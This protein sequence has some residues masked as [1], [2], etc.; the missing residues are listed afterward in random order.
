MSTRL[1]ILLGATLLAACSSL[2]QPLDAGMP[3][4]PDGGD[5]GT[6]D[7]GVPDSGALPDAG[8]P[9]DA[10]RTDDAGT[11]SSTP[12]SC[13]PTHLC[14]GESCCTSLLVPGGTFMYSNGT[15]VTVSPFR[16][17]KYEVT[18]G[19]F[20]AFVDAVAAGWRPT[21]GMG[22][23]HHLAGGGLVG[24]SGWDATLTP[25]AATTEEWTALL[26]PPCTGRECTLRR[27]WTPDA[28]VNETRPITNVRWHEAL[29]FC[30][31]DNG[32]LPT[33][34]EWE[35][36]AVGGSEQRQYPQGQLA[37]AN[38]VSLPEPRGPS[39]DGGEQWPF[40]GSRPASAGR[41]GHL[42]LAGGVVEPMLDGYA[43]PDP[44]KNCTDCAYVYPTAYK[45]ARSWPDFR[46]SARPSVF[47]ERISYEDR[48]GELNVG[49][50]FI[51]VRCARAQ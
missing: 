43:D 31:W 25:L 42:D 5:A 37:D 23:H 22:R 13:S 33:E 17:D 36:A 2:Q 24:E 48:R 20:R 45:S 40:V 35:F 6:E 14:N 47:R 18:V 41:W 29:A 16:L 30:I 10:G 32:F 7:G 11:P 28:G 4:G 12:R 38:D 19:R 34:R 49:V 51:G 26:T 8:E 39:A 27:T 9:R 21:R 44:L 50:E 15:S 3:S 1:K 46:Q